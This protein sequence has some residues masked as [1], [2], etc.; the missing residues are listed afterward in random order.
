MI[1]LIST[2]IIISTISGCIGFRCYFFRR[3]KKLIAL[4]QENREVSKRLS[5]NYYR[6]FYIRLNYKSLQQYEDHSI[7][8]GFSLY[9]AEHPGDFLHIYDIMR[10]D[11]EIYK[12][13]QEKTKKI[14]LASNDR[15]LRSRIE[16]YYFRKSTIPGVQTRFMV[17]KSYTTRKKRRHYES[18]A[19]IS[20]DQ[21]M[22]ICCQL[23]AKIKR[24]SEA[25][26]ERSRMNA[27]LR[28]Q[29][30]KRDG[31]H[32][33]ICGRGKEDGVVLQVDHIKPV[34]KGGKTELSNL[35][36]LCSL[37]NYGKGDSYVPG[38]FN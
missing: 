11:T 6:T 30:L 12:A 32:C 34:S 2:L 7:E 23:L 31:L 24:R 19:I 37:C 1:L 33:V 13:Y 18:T 8:H 14:L 22:D 3:S 27:S 15:T 38:E 21:F 29:V 20:A 17:T 25:E 28:Y 26:R 4:V 5:R 10:Q 35:R 9:V 36:T 16:D